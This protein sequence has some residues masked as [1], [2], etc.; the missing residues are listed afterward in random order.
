VKDEHFVEVYPMESKAMAGEAL[1]QMGRD[2]GI[3]ANLT[4]DGSKEE[5]TAKGSLF[6]Q[7]MKKNDVKFHI[8]EPYRH[9]Q[10]RAET[11][12]RELKRK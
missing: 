6:M 2:Y 3:M 5:Q 4:I 11:V 10:N 8:T 1:R 12:I 9:N 7:T